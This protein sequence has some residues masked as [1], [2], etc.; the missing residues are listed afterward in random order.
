M[1]VP[2]LLEIC[3]KIT[4]LTQVRSILIISYN[5]NVPKEKY[6]NVNVVTPAIK[7]L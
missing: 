5:F 6:G 3:R 2:I 7:S 1:T 4:E